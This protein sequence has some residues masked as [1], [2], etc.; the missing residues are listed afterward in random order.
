MNDTHITD[1]VVEGYG[2]ALRITAGGRAYVY[3]G[4]IVRSS[5]GTYGVIYVGASALLIMTGGRIENCT[6]GTNGGAL[7]NEGTSELLDTVVAGCT[8]GDVGGG[9][10]SSLGTFT[11]V[12]GSISDCRA[13]GGGGGGGVN[14]A[15]GTTTLEGVAIERCAAERGGGV[16]VGE[17]GN[18][19][20]RRS[21]TI[22]PLVSGCTAAQ[23][24]GGVAAGGSVVVEH[25]MVVHCR[26]D[27]WGAQMALDFRPSTLPQA[28]SFICECARAHMRAHG[29]M[30]HQTCRV[31]CQAVAG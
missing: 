10:S 16:A 24:G 19:T 15:G 28:P 29:G 9:V 27:R 25:A 8:A 23:F 7:R 11:M 30:L 20:L 1:T 12:R 17:R 26:A 22:A 31:V 18:A 21:G 6:A 3:G 13:S 4:S 14:V 5:A 2:S